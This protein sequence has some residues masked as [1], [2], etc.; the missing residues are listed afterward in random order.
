VKRLLKR[1]GIA[2][3]AAGILLGALAAGLFLPLTVTS[4][5]YVR[6]TLQTDPMRDDPAQLRTAFLS[7]IPKGSPTMLPR[8]VIGPALYDQHC[9]SN[10]ASVTCTFDV[11]A[12]YFGT[13]RRG[14]AFTLTLD[15]SKTIQDVRFR[16]YREPV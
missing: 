16:T 6:N 10:D 13:L 7:L 11:E 12:S 1:K 8:D 9:R 3:G 4:G 5:E 14:F 15:A 2:L